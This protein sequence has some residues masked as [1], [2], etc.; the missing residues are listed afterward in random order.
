MGSVVT[1]ANFALGQ[2]WLSGRR[3]EFVDT[4]VSVLKFS[5]TVFFPIN[6]VCLVVMVL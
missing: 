5:Y 3:R 1:S 6:F 2:H 4:D